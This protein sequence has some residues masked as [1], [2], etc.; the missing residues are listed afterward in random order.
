MKHLCEY[1]HHWHE[2]EKSRAYSDDLAQSWIREHLRSGFLD[3]HLLDCHR[4]T[5]ISLDDSVALS[6]TLSIAPWHKDT[7]RREA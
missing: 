2:G 6:R 4:M 1:C 7:R 3:C 5:S